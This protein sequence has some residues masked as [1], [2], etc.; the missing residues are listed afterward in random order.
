MKL[1]TAARARLPGL[2]LLLVIVSL[3]AWLR[4]T[5][6][7]LCELKYDEAVALELA[8]P[9]VD[10]TG[11]PRVGLISSVEV[12]NP[13][14]MMYLLALPMW[15]SIDPVFVTGFVGLLAVV[16]VAL[17]FFVLRRRFGELVA[18]GTCALWATAP[19]AVLYAR[20]LW[21]QS[22]LAIFV[23]L[24]LHVLFIV[25][26]RRKTWHIAW[27]PVLLCALG[28]LHLSAIAALPLLALFVVWRGRDVRWA[29]AFVGLAA[30]VLMLAPYLHHQVE[31]KWSDF[32]LAAQAM[33]RAEHKARPADL[34]PLSLTADLL[35]SRGFAY[36][37]GGSDGAFREHAGVARKLARGWTWALTGL[38][39]LAFVFVGAGLLRRARFTRRF[40]YVELDAEDA[41]RAVLWTWVAGFWAFFI[42]APLDLFPHY[43][44]I[45]YPA[46]FVLTLLFL[47]DACDLLAERW[48]RVARWATIGFVAATALSFVAFDV[49]FFGF[50]RQHRGT[51][52]DYGAVYADKA[53]AVRYALE[54]DL[55]V[56]G[57]QPEIG[58]LLKLRRRGQSPR[59]RKGVM[60][61]WDRHRGGGH[62]AQ[63]P[64]EKRREMGALTACLR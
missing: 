4:W 43:F 17:T 14:L 50:L 23:V 33:K 56:V 5:E 8:M 13:P 20:K 48:R 12:R 36:V 32:R 19:W 24:L 34:R 29:A 16:A 26:E 55:D 60:Q 62:G 45:L 22:L 57:G 63:C 40:P 52:G 3:A 59:A 61:L 27:V 64:A 2:T 18:L 35:G 38:F 49:S 6:L 46:P 54:H 39:A 44:I 47:K 31:T 30:G 1:S 15:A 28:Q 21:A 37:T 9:L 51:S 7:A 10:G 41:L 11:F 58:L 42:V 53:T 25:V